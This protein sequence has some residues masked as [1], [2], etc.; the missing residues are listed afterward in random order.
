MS[1]RNGIQIRVGDHSPLNKQIYI[2]IQ[3]FKNHR[4]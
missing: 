3:I 4:K 2:L 1:D